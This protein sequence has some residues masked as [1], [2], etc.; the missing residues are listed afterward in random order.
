MSTTVGVKYVSIEQEVERR[1]SHAR[2]SRS[3]HDEPSMKYTRTS[4]GQSILSQSCLPP[5][6][7]SKGDSLGT[8]RG[9]GIPCSA[10][11]IGMLVLSIPTLS[12]IF[13]IDIEWQMSNVEGGELSRNG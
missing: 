6:G 8:W 1:R 12:T 2:I 3:T 11:A 9:S 7:L 10:V 13:D 4:T 5:Q